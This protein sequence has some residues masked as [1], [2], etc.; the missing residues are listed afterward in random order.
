VRCGR[1]RKTAEAK[2][3]RNTQK[4]R[5]LIQDVV[6]TDMQNRLSFRPQLNPS[7]ARG[8]QTRCSLGV[9]VYLQNTAAKCC[10]DLQ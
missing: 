2:K 3:P 8:R 5:T 10:G 7:N 6:M 4:K 9:R 1:D